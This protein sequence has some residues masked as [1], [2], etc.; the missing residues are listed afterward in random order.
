LRMIIITSRLK[1]EKTSTCLL[2][3]VDLFSRKISRLEALFHS[4]KRANL[5]SKWEWY[6]WQWSEWWI[7]DLTLNASHDVSRFWW[8]VLFL[9]FWSIVRLIFSKNW[10]NDNFNQSSKKRLKILIA[11]RWFVLSSWSCCAFFWFD[12]QSFERIV[13]QRWIDS[14]LSSRIRSDHSQHN[15]EKRQIF[16]RSHVVWKTIDR[17][18][19]SVFNISH[20]RIRCL[21]I[22][23]C[24][25]R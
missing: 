10:K 8:F 25:S 3:Q 13:I 18:Q 1:S 20:V 2:R 5:N 9:R 6:H 23:W 21:K 19:I 22:E 11:F 15:R 7:F 12:E 14:K 4:K 16:F 17:Q 24:L